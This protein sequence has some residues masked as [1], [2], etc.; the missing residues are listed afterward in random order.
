MLSR[1]PL[2]LPAEL[3]GAEGGRVGRSIYWIEGGGCWGGG[4]M[5][6]P[7]LLLTRSFQQTERGFLRRSLPPQD[8]GSHSGEVDSGS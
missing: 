3:R 2:L 6:G 8:R 7:Y 1:R 5:L 4:S